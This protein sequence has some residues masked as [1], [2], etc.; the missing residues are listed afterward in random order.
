MVAVTH[1]EAA[2]MV[3]RRL[4]QMGRIKFRSSVA[5][6]VGG[7]IQYTYTHLVGHVVV[8]ARIHHGMWTHGIAVHILD[9]LVPGICI[10]ACHLRD[11]HEVPRVAA[12]RVYL[13]VEQMAC[14]FES[15]LSPS[16]AFIFRIDFLAS[17]FG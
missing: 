15:P 8:K 11:T 5:C 16:K 17:C 12:Q 1:H 9:G 3:F 6:P 13:A 4:L 2:Q 10:A 7:F 14:A